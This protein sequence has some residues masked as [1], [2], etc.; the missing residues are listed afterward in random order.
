[1]VTVRVEIRKLRASTANSFCLHS[2][3]AE[4]VTA[5]KHRM[6]VL[7]THLGDCVSALRLCWEAM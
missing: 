7:S 6:R 4:D 1:V 3:M 2:P 5:G